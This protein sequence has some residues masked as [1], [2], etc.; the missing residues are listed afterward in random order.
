MLK[1]EILFTIL[2]V[3]LSIILPFYYVY[4]KKIKKEKFNQQILQGKKVT[5]SEKIRV[6]LDNINEKFRAKH[7]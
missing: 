2:I 3:I 1:L 6:Y 7:K 4:K 5:E